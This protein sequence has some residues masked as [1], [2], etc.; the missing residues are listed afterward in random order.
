[1][2]IVDA[3]RMMKVLLLAGLLAS[4]VVHA[5]GEQTGRIFGTIT[6]AASG[7]PVPGATVTISGTQLIGGPRNLTSGD[8]GRYEAVGLPPGRYDIEVSY[9]GVKP[10]KRRVVVR[11]GETT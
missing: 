8:D 1:M 11:L 7:A 4:S 10:I 9:A 5:A 6:E 2:Q 3:N